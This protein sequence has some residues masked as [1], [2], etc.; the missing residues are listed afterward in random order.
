MKKCKNTECKNLIEGKKVYCSLTCRNVF[1]NKNIRDY[2]GVS[3]TLHDKSFNDYEKTPK[4]CMNIECGKKI[5]YHKKRNNFCDSSCS[6]KYSNKKRTYYWGVEISKGVKNNLRKKNKNIISEN[7]KK[8][9]NCGKSFFGRN[10][11]C[12]I[13]CSKNNR[14]KGWDEFYT[15]KRDCQFSFNLSD[16]NEEFDFSLVKKYG[17]YKPKNKGDNLG[18]I[19]RDHMIS[20]MDGFEKKISPKIISHPANCKLMIHNDNVRKYRS[21]SLT[22]DELLERIDNWNKKYGEW[23]C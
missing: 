4:Y 17:W 22:I 18:G 1:V 5:P 10:K 12:S 14:R 3:K 9:Q 19:S 8:C 15:Y 21:S 7:E 16:F 11:Y 20:I 2:S 6:A 13:I 23:G